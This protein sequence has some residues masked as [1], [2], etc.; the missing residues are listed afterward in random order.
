MIVIKRIP[1][2]ISKHEPICKLVLCYSCFVLKTD[3]M[4]FISQHNFTIITQDYPMV[5]D[6]LLHGNYLPW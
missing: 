1:Y 6:G 4:I 3:L 5:G 2:S